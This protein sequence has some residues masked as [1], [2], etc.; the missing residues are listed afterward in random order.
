M[1]GSNPGA[2][3]FAF[4]V[5]VCHLLLVF[6][7]VSL[8]A[9]PVFAQRGEI[10][11]QVLDQAGGLIPDVK[12]SLL[13]L[14]L[15]LSRELSST[16][17]GVF[18]FPL[19]QP[20]EYVLTAQRTGFGSAEV[21]D[22]RLIADQN[23]RLRLILRVGVQSTVIRVSD[24]SDPIFS[25]SPSLGG[26]VAAT[27]LNETPMVTRDVTSLALLFPGVLPSPPDPYGKTSYR[28][29]GSRVD[30][31]TFLLDDGL[32]NDLLYNQVAYMPNL[33]SIA[34][35]RVQ[36]SSYPAEYGRN[37]GG[38][39]SMVTK[40]GSSD[41]HGSV[42]DYFR[43]DRLN[44]NSFFD[45]FKGIPRDTYLL[46]QFG[47]SLGG[48]GTLLNRLAGEKKL[49]YFI[50]Y[51]GFR[52]KQR[53]SNNSV[54]TYTP[55]ELQGDFSQAGPRNP[56]TGQPAPDPGVASFLLAHPYFQPDA[57]KAASAII[58]PAKFDSV[59]G[60]YI[61]GGLIPTSPTGYATSQALSFTDADELITKLDYTPGSTDH[62]SL[63]FGANRQDFTNPFAFANVPGFATDDQFRSGFFSLSYSKAIT[64]QLLNDFKVSANRN[65]REFQEPD[66]IQP[67]A[68]DLGVNIHPDLST[69]PSLL[70][71]SSGLQVG[72]GDKG[73][74]RYVSNTYTFGDTVSWERSAHHLTAGA[75]L[76]VFQNN[77]NT[78]YLVNGQFVFYGTSTSSDLADFLLGLPSA[79]LQAANSS[80]Y[81]RSKFMFGFLQDEWKLTPTLSINVGLRY[82]Y[83]TPKTDTQ[84]HLFSIVPGHQSTQFPNAPVGM[85]FPG[86]AG[87]PRATNF[88]DHNNFAPRF[89]F[90]WSPRSHQR[91]RVR[92]GFGVFCD[93]LNA[94]DNLQFNGQEPFASSANLF[95]NPPPGPNGP[96]N[97]LSSPFQ[98]AGVVDPFPSRNPP[99]NLDFAA[100]GLL[101]IGDLLRNVFVVDP[102]LRTPYTYQYGVNLQLKLSSSALLQIGYV[103]NSAHSL[104]ALTDVNPMVLGTANRILNLTP[105]NSS[106]TSQTDDKCSFAAIR[107]FKSIASANYDALEIL[108][109]KSFSQSPQIGG[110]YF[111]LGYTY[112]HTIDNASGFDSRNPAV[113]SYSPVLFRASSDSDLRHRLVASGGWTLPLHYHLPELPARL[114]NGWNVAGMLSW[115]TGFPLDV[116]ADLPATYDFTSPGPS[117]AGDPSLVRANLIAPYQELNP[118]LN[119]TLRGIAGNYWFS[120]TSFSNSQC[121]AASNSCVAGPTMF[122][123]DAQV[124]VNPALRTYGTLPR[125]FFRGPGQTNLDFAFGKTTPLRPEVL[126][127]EARVELFNALNHTQFANPNTNINDYFFGQITDTTS[128]RVIQLGLRL[129]F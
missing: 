38:I 12:L 92:G 71:F 47:A 15:G 115:R 60:N 56:V 113:P 73:T 109:R 121:P 3:S 40:S 23:L 84:N 57:G 104:T 76:S 14:T 64:P 95:F 93:I 67:S 124:L 63:T 68:M 52:Q 27:V 39:I 91:F 54:F 99:H 89:S 7:S 58:D 125:N 11:G 37:A 74:S 13:N 119:S 120:P 35:F 21:R 16:D 79:Y 34:E 123:S 80:S 20:G 75:G 24:A 85:L 6:L 117:G 110:S 4:K 32:D 116:F 22:L 102:R 83:S 122:P 81:T 36:T 50:S 19:L 114:T 72:F 44:A 86:D 1:P 96:Q 126:S 103:G 8:L 31:V 118:R 17:Q 9:S 129:V 112:S 2:N 111:T 82:E 30:T 18:H 25:T 48:P 10:S 43:N 33:D 107:E 88:P 87:A 106:C 90:T 70:L 128:P 100:N 29:S 101:P 59:A 55:A 51:E 45:N 77:S 66:S 62:L 26:T 28:I 49:F 108:L 97:F 53:L 41:L 105:G 65:D 42:F 98:A 94:E 61:K 46:N 69:G 78:S 127:M 5:N